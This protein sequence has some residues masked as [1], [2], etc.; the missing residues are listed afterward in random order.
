[1]GSLKINEILKGLQHK[2]DE[3]HIVID[4]YLSGYIYNLDLFIK[5]LNI[6]NFYA[7]GKE[8]ELIAKLA[9]ITRKSNNFNISR[10]SFYRLYNN[11]KSKTPKQLLEKYDLGEVEAETLLPSMTIYKNLMNL[12]QSSQII[13]STVTIETEVIRNMLFDNRHRE[14]KK[15]SFKNI[16]ASSRS[17]AKKYNYNQEHAETIEKIALDIFDALKERFQLSEKERV[18]LQAA[19]ILHDIGKY[20]NLKKHYEHSY[21]LIRNSDIAD[22]NSYDKNIIAHISLNH[23]Q[24]STTNLKIKDN[25]LKNHSDRVLIAKLTA[26]LK[27]A[28][29]LDKSHKEPFSE[30]EINLEENELELIINTEKDIFLE[31]WAFSNKSRIFKEIFGI[32]VSLN[33]KN[34]LL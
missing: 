28:D 33:K 29:S 6:N 32:D 24:S 10:A 12:T 21:Y 1:M 9:G 18:L 7:S 4:G 25:T 17:V 23:S 2:T 22:L 11:V 19:V 34:T 30:L 16:I 27:I 20:M 14:L 13:G 3:F 31:K 15:Q 26:I 8:I 5:K